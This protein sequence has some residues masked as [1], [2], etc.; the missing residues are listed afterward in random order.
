MILQYLISLQKS[1]HLQFRGLRQ[2]TG[3][4][5]EV[6]VHFA[7]CAPFSLPLCTMLLEGTIITKPRREKINFHHFSREGRLY[8]CRG[9][10][11][12]THVLGYEVSRCFL[13]TDICRHFSSIKPP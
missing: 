2:F 12:Q 13:M 3:Q 5:E 7:V 1:L 11:C 9:A 6:I 10:H 8:K 4:V